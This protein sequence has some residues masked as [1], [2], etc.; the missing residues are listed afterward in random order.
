MH[1][2]QDLASPGKSS[3]HILKLYVLNPEV[4]R[5]ADFPLVPGHV[6]LDILLF[7]KSVIII[8]PDPFTFSHLR[9]MLNDFRLSP[10]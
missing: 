4:P 1:F 7:C 10:G 3:P 5:L 6:T 9:T 2:F 8:F